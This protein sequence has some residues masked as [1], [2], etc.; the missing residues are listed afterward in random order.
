[1]N[2]DTVKLILACFG[3]GGFAL[4]YSVKKIRIN[5]LIQDTPTS[6][7][8]SAAQGFNELQGYAW[9]L[10]ATAKCSQKN[11][12]VYYTITLQKYV[13]RHKNSKWETVF[14]RNLASDFLILDTTGAVHVM[15]PKATLQIQERTL[16]WSGLNEAS[17]DH[18]LNNLLTAVNVSGF[19]PSSGFIGGLFS[20]KFRIVEN[21][22]TLASPLLILGEFESPQKSLMEAPPSPGLFGFFD[23]L[24][25]DPRLKIGATSSFFD[26][27]KDG[28]VDASELRRGLYYMAKSLIN[29]STQSTSPPLNGSVPLHGIIKKSDNH[30]LIIIDSHEKNLSSYAEWGFYLLFIAGSG[31]ILLALFIILNPHRFHP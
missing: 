26:L 30:D 22:I 18:I 13:K 31:L 23:K 1:M 10:N 14:A 27:N 12:C 15:V 29:A 8:R 28:K 9:P 2:P 20:A 17:R 11:D 21:Y 5:R 25:K 4:W 16:K 7:T 24:Q 3:G 19:P 6:R